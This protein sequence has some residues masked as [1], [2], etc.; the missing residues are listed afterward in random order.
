MDE[1]GALAVAELL[2][3]RGVDIEIGLPTAESA[4]LMMRSGI[5]KRAIR[6]LLEAQEQTLPEALATMNAVEDVIKECRVPRLLHGFDAMTWPLIAEA[7]RRGYDTRVGLEDTF[8]LP[9]GS[10]ARNNAELV[11]AARALIAENQRIK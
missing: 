9:D 5:W 3:S 1:D 7:A 10:P 6:V 2:L 8:L 11:E 4:E